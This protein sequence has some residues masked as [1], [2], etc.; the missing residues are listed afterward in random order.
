[1]LAQ[2]V[3]REFGGKVRFVSEN[4]GDS[5]LAK[6]FGVTR[7][8]AIFV[9]DVLVASPKDFGFYGKGEGSGDGR[10]TPLKSAASHERFRAD[11]SRMIS[12]V[13]AGRK[14]AARASAPREPAEIAAM[15][16]INLTDLDGKPLTKESLAGKAVLVEFWATWCPP[17][18]GTLAWLG[19]LKKRYGDRLTI[20]A[21]AV[22]SDEAAVRKVAADTKLP[23]V[24]AMGTP[25]LARSFGD[26]SAVPTLF[27]F[28]Q[29]GAA[30]ATFYGA[31]PTLHAEAESR[32]ATLL[33]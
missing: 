6:K 25:D 14:D 33:R 18:R 3:V 15:P 27:A 26:T 16:A 29:K 1:M 7:Y 31:P 8:P 13:L 2:G 28:D 20:I 10:Y 21:I 17:C 30:A 5:D 23:L 19:D 4:Y 11:L 32:L 12:L 24:W 9:D 22:E